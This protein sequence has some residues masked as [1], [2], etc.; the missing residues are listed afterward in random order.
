MIVPL[1]AAIALHAPPCFGDGVFERY[2]AKDVAALTAL[3]ADARTAGDSL[4][5]RYR[6]FPLTQDRRWI[7]DLAER[8]TATSAE[9]LALLSG[10]WAYRIQGSSPFNLIRF[11]RRSD[12]FLQRARAIAPDDPFVLLVEGQSLLF[13]PGF[14]GGDAR[15]ALDHFRTL[16]DRLRAHPA[17][18]IAA[19][20]AETW[21]WLAMRK[22]RDP[23]AEAY[24][25]QLLAR[26]LPT[27][28]AEFLRD[29]NGL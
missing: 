2:A 5:W 24:R 18:G 10:L 15:A 23:G 9:E 4:L 16:R 14:V 7:R 3:G 1:L 6:L 27:L 19:L 25:Q 26:G 13:R 20:E 29:D 11:A 12:G 17:C 8:S 28:F 21:M 22:A